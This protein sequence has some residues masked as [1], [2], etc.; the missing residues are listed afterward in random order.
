M[1]YFIIIVDISNFFMLFKVNETK[2]NTFNSARSFVWKSYRI[3]AGSEVKEEEE[4]E[5]EMRRRARSGGYVRVR[6]D[7]ARV[8]ITIE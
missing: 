2:L 3:E 8:R 7:R 1:L 4:V 6:I 5:E